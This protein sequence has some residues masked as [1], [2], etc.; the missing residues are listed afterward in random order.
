M[1]KHALRTCE[2]PLTLLY[3]C[4]VGPCQETPPTADTTSYSKFGPRLGNKYFWTTGTG[5]SGSGTSSLPY[6]AGSYDAALC[7][8]KIGNANITSYSSV[9][10]TGAKEYNRSDY[11]T[12]W[13]EVVE[14]ILANT[15][16]SVAYGE[17]SV[18]LASGLLQSQVFEGETYLGS[19]AC[20]YS[21]NSGS[22]GKPS[23]DEFQSITFQ[24]IYE[25]IERRY[26][27][28]VEP[29]SEMQ[30][31]K[32]MYTKDGL[33]SFTPFKRIYDEVEIIPPTAEG[34]VKHGTVLA[35]IVFTE[36]LY[37]QIA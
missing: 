21:S 33:H 13:G 9:F 17:Q 10:P 32:M 22:G 37:P 7:G 36:W 28:L 11:Q 30:M 3:Y 35:G 16:G 1:Y 12:T 4:R 29:E 2:L 15:N 5:Q 8:A 31:G 27:E 19:F 23:E 6:E 18:K 34:G 26:G 24:D 20:E 25:M 14:V